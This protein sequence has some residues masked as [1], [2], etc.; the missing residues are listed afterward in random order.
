[1]SDGIHNDIIIREATNE[2]SQFILHLIFNIWI[3][4]YHFQVKREDFPDLHEIENYY[5]KTDGLFLVASRNN[6]ILG[7]IACSKLS[8]RC[9]VLKRMFVNKDYRRLG[10][11][12]AL[13]NKLFDKIVFSKKISN[14]SL[15]LSTKESEAIAAKRFYIK[16]GFRV[17]PMSALPANF[18]FFYRDDLFMLKDKWDMN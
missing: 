12:Q 11:A 7:T 4:E 15:F 9:F 16:N 3:N 18:P 14:L 13:L 1:M 5:T 2:D 6:E 8:H 10:I 17:A